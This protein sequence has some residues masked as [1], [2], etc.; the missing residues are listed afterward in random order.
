MST[1]VPGQHRVWYSPA[2]GREMHVRWFGHGGAHLIAFPTTMGNHNEWPNR[3]MPDV[4][5]EHIEKGWIQ[6]WCPDHNHDASWYD[7]KAHPGHRAW[8]HLRYDAYIRDELLPFMRHVNDNQ[9]VIATGASFGAFHAASIA[10]RNPGLFHR[11]IGMS[12]TY[13]I[14]GMTGGYSDANVYAC[15]PFDFVQHEKDPRRLD[16]L[17][18]MDI[19]LAI[20]RGDPHFDENCDFSALMWKRGIGNALRVW[21]GHAHDWPYWERMIVT[22]VGGHD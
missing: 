5:R 14:K 2:V 20:G 11:L 16:A 13:D 15:N 4:L 10:L 12:G 7:K 3:Y 22:Y 17:R 9:F 19:I 8:L 1:R 6:L 21:D 18:R